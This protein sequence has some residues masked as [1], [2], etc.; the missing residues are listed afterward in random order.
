[1][2]KTLD[3]KIID[4]IIQL[5]RRGHSLP[6]I[7]K[8]VGKGSAT[9]SKYIQEVDILPE[10]YNI[11]K[12]KQGGSK[13]RADQK[14]KEANN[15]A[16]KIVSSLNR[17]ERLL[18]AACLYWGEGTKTELNLANTDPDLVRV[19]IECLKDIGVTKD[20]LRITI[21]IYEDIDKN[22]AMVYWAKV[23]GIP[24]SQ[25]LGVNILNGK[26]SGKLKYGMCRV[27]VTKGA[28][29]FKILKSV[30]E[31]IKVNIQPS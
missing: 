21:R 12:N 1:M 9:V 14:W 13:I 5:R 6:E 8:I 2:S 3:K 18:I 24:K 10:Y 19:F 7:R 4:K 28:Q 17:K 30:I 23:I 20:R 31:L 25:I 11:W 29:Y 15:K 26:K 27:R 16:R 22:K